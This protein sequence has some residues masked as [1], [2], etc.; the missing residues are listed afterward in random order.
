VLVVEDDPGDARL[1]QR[2]LLEDGPEAFNV[3]LA[4]SLS[5]ARTLIDTQGLRPDVV[6]LDLNLPDSTGIA[7]VEAFR[8]LS[9][10]PVVVLTGLDDRAAT[11]AAIQSGAEDF[12]TKDGDGPALRKAIRYTML[13]HQRDNDARLTAT[14]FAHAREGIVIAAPDGTIIKVNDTFT[15][16]T[17]YTS[18]EA[19]G[20]NTRLLRSGRHDPEFY[21][22]MWRDLNEKGEWHGEIWNR[23]K[24][25]EIYA[26]LLTISTVKDAR[27]TV[28]HYVA[29]FSD[30]TER[31]KAEEQI[32]QVSEALQQLNETLEMRV[33]E[34]TVQ[35]EAANAQLEVSASELSRSNQ[36]LEQFAYIASHDLQE[37]VRTVVGF[38][39]LLEKRLAGKLDPEALEFMNYAVNGALHMQKLIQG[40]LMYSRVG[41]RAAPSA[42]VDSAV[43]AQEALDL[44]ND[45]VSNSGAQVDMVA[46]PIVAADRTQLVQLFQN[47]IGNAIKFCPHGAPR[48]R[49]EACRDGQQ[50]RFAITDNGI[51]I[52]P[53]YR[54]RIFIIFQRLHTR[55]EYEGTGIG[56]AICK[57]IVHRHGGRI[58]VESTGDKQGSRFMFTLPGEDPGAS[59]GA[60]P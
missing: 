48:V 2:Q 26:E 20:H 25:G 36:E 29:L 32:R 6:L 51:G 35:L 16:I 33:R 49:I 15:L 7:T 30:I 31:K 56:L 3:H 14:V 9:D 12:L 10:A 52:S 50:W 40:I 57:R 47:L 55:S 28:R 23:R 54:E 11:E 19:L 43:A 45:K 17:G 1:I 60:I 37:P 34:R 53:E 58:W 21:R 42:P 46:L 59:E 38:V 27:G 41:S 18:E 39:Q 5:A 13:R 4:N 8:A 44:L 24:S 22:A